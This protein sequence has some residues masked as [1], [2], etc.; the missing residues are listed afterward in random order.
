VLS[1]ILLHSFYVSLVSVCYLDLVL[2]TVPAK[3][4]CTF[5]L[6]RFIYNWS[7]S[8]NRLIRQYVLFYIFGGRHG[9]DRMVVGFFF[10]TIYAISAYH[11][12]WYEFESGSGRCVQHYMIKFVS[13]LWQVGGFLRLPPPIKL[14]AMI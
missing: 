8:L 12:W 2:C 3:L 1:Y 11:H 6:V 4:H 10:T 14:T 7:I 5:I 13:D 9:R